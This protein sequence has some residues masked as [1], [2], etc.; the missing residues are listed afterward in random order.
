LVVEGWSAGGA[1][2]ALLKFFKQI[3]DAA[4]AGATVLSDRNTWGVEGEYYLTYL[5]DRQHATQSYKLAE[6]AKFKADII[7][8]LAMSITPVA[9]TL[10][11]KIDIAL[12]VKPYLAIRLRRIESGT[13][14]M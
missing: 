9:G 12:P 7:D 1:N 5:W 3:V 10:S 4:P 11:G 13:S 6:D 14:S 2:P 8:T